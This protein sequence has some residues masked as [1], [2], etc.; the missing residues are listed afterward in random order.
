MIELS[1]CAQV[2]RKDHRVKSVQRAQTELTIRDYSVNCLTANHTA[3]AR[4]KCMDWREEKDEQFSLCTADR[5]LSLCSEQLANDSVLNCT[6]M[7]N[8]H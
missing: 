5:V 3:V 7:G 4:F 6:L 1:D 8:L 2:S